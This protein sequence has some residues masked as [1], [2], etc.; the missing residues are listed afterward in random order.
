VSDVKQIIHA[1]NNF[2]DSG[3]TITNSKTANAF[4]DLVIDATKKKLGALLDD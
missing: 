4:R 2:F 1:M 3:F